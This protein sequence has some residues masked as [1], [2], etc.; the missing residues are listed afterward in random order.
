MT[1]E[2]LPRQVGNLV[3][4]SVAPCAPDS[5]IRYPSED[6]FQLGRSPLGHRTQKCYVQEDMERGEDPLGIPSVRA[7]TE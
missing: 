1:I 7:A 6:G 3:L 5:L 4:R 2:L